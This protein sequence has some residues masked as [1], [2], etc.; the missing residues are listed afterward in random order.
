MV[1][2]GTP[3][4]D[5]VTEV[6]GEIEF[7]VISSSS[8]IYYYFRP[9]GMQSNGKLYDSI[10]VTEARLTNIKTIDTEV[11]MEIMLKTVTDR[12]SGYKGKVISLVV[13]QN[14]CIHAVVQAK[15]N[16]DGTIPDN[17]ERSILC[18]SGSCI[19]NKTVSSIVESVKG[20]SPSTR[21]AK[22]AF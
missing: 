11:P 5:S 14:G 6:E 18:L 4:K 16:K 19:N 1:K 7:A 10:M 8:E 13:H 21:L 2:L 22:V 15:A 20:K 17:I 9:K 3:V 12:N